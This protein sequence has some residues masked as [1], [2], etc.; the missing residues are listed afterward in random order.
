M[1]FS[2]TGLL[3]DFASC[4]CTHGVLALGSPSGVKPFFRAASAGGVP[5]RLGRTV[6]ASPKTALARVTGSPVLYVKDGPIWYEAVRD[7]RIRGIMVAIFPGIWC[8]VAGVPRARVHRVGS[9]PSTVLIY[10]PRLISFSTVVSTCVTPTHPL[11]S[12]LSATH[13]ILLEG[14]R[15]APRRPS[16]SPTLRTALLEGHN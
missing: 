2:G 4:S 11:P 9:A 5:E 16:R 8:C 6:H 15:R 10:R 13:Y 1:S 3:W 12:L 14:R 7:N